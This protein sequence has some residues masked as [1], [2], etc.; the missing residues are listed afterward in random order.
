MCCGT[1]IQ[2]WERNETARSVRGDVVPAGSDLAGALVPGLLHA[3]LGTCSSGPAEPWDENSLLCLL[4][5]ESKGH[6]VS[7]ERQSGQGNNL[8]S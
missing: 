3:W 4:I 2:V 8:W 7:V 6:F 5:L 1:V